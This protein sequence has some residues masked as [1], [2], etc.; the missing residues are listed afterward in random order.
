MKIIAFCFY[1]HSTKRTNFL[2][3]FLQVVVTVLEFPI[4][5]LQNRAS[6]R[7]ASFHMVTLM[8]QSHKSG[9]E[10]QH[11]QND[12]QRDNYN[13]LAVLLTLKGSL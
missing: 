3:I 1:F 7:I 5:V 13:H 11:D 4:D 10:T 6:L 2:V 8:L 12:L 9:W